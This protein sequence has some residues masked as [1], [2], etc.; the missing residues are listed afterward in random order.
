MVNSLAFQTI[1]AA[2]TLAP[3]PPLLLIHG[4]LG[5]AHDWRPIIDC[6]SSVN[7]SLQRHV[8]AVDLP[9]HGESPPWDDG[10]L[11]FS[12]LCDSLASLIIEQFTATPPIIVGYSL[13]GRLALQLARRHP[14]LLHSLVM[15]AAHPGLPSDSETKTASS[16]RAER[17]ALDLARAHEVTTTPWPVF[18][19]RWYDLGIFA[20]LRAHPVIRDQIITQ[21]LAHPPTAP[22]P[23][24]TALS[25]AHQPPPPRTVA[26]P[27][28]QI[29]GSLD[30]AYHH[31]AHGAPWM[32][33]A[34]HHRITVIEGVGHA[35]VYEAAREV[36][37]LLIGGGGVR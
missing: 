24:L 21:R 18:I 35:V 27:T 23:L 7:H 8:V 28:H 33:A 13:G 10:T 26:T 30:P 14:K 37:A 9:G 5:S 36:A 12:S 20:S 32:K 6:L 22:A 15:I 16:S 17:F 34:T 19:E 4:W 25:V 1:L 29:V 11:T 31:L 3:A 2:P